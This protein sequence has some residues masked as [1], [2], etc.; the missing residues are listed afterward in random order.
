MDDEDEDEDE[1]AEEGR[2]DMGDGAGRSTGEKRLLLVEEA[3]NGEYT[4]DE[5]GDEEAVA[6]YGADRVGEMEADDDEAD[7]SERWRPADDAM[8]GTD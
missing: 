7:D 4:V 5:A 3:E 6:W 2:D 8:D 1:E